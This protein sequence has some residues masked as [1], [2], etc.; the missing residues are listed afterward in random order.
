MVF[1]A[2]G[3]S[4]GLDRDGTQAGTDRVSEGQ[5]SQDLEGLDDAAVTFR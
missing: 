4:G 3:G 5:L 1:S 2:A